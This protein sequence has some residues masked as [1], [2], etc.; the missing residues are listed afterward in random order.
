MTA[1]NHLYG[2]SGIMEVSPRNTT[3]RGPAW[4]RPV[5]VELI[6]PEDNGGFAVDAGIRVQGGDYIRGRYNYRGGSPPENK[7]SFRL[8]FRGEYGEGPLRYP[9]FPGT[10][11]GSF[12]R[13]VLRAGMNDHTNPFLAD[14]YVRALAADVGQPAALGTFV[15]LF[16]NGV[17]RGYY[18][19]CERIDPDFLRAYHGGGERWD[20]I[21]QMGEVREGDVTAWNALKA[22][23][24]NP[25]RPLTV[26]AN[27][28]AVADRLDLVNFCDYLLPLI[29][30]DVDDWPHNNWRAARERVPGGKFRFYVWDA[31]WAFGLSNGHDP[32][33]NTIA[34]QLSTT[35]PPWGGVEIQ[36]IFNALKRA[37]EFQLLMA[38][39]VHRHFF[40]G[41]ALTDAR[42]RTRYNDVRGRLNNVVAGF[43]DRIGQVWI[44][45][46]RT[47]V[48]RH[49]H[50]AGFHQSSNAPA[51]TPFGGRVAPGHALVVTNLAGT[52]WYTTNGA[53]P[54][55]PFTGAVHPDARAY[56]GPLALGGDLHFLARSLN[57]TNWS[58]LSEAVFQAGTLTPAIRFSE[59]MYHPP[60]GDA[61]EYLELLNAGGAPVDLSGWSFEGVNFRIP[62]PF[63]P[64]AP[65][66]R[67]VF[68][69]G[70]A[71]NLFRQRYGAV[72][73]AGW[74][75]G[76]L[77]NGGE[78]D[79]E[80][81]NLSVAALRRFK[82]IAEGLHAG[83]IRAIATCAV[84][85][86]TN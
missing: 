86:A 72:P 9:L 43:N 81:I 23:C 78:L 60:G 47:Q 48:L 82:A 2:A 64:L 71:T 13:V 17:Y 61:Y 85:E 30:A 65:G 73:V 39:R 19:P 33:F 53:D 37:P 35:S 3:R 8:Y 69:N 66:A 67:L 59:L 45:Q 6:R 5:S 83:R 40:H 28:R 38:D 36:Q 50:Q 75:S 14:E 70:T 55:V 77:A 58:A 21:A 63:P 44:P 46:R 27:Y 62:T 16:L 41:G 52:I 18:N 29:W 42:L 32:N 49:L 26:E 10:T 80:S 15:H 56:A 1:T 76:A 79:E 34:N 12:D 74:Y 11:Q 4:E 51:F 54:R 57:G 25:S 84:R 24:N 31:E 68:A 7:Y 20:G 22:L